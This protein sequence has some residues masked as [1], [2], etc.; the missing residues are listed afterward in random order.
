MTLTPFLCAVLTGGDV[1]PPVVH[2]E[3]AVSADVLAAY[4]GTY[5]LSQPQPVTFRYVKQVCRSWLMG[6]SDCRSD[7]RLASG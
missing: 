1:P 2:K 7:R 3:I 4:P 6:S 5:E